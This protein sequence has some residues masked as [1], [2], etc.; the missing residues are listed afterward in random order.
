MICV[1]TTVFLFEEHKYHRG[2]SQANRMCGGKQ[3]YVL[4]KTIPC[5]KKFE[6]VRC[7]DSAASSFVVKF[8]AEV[9]TYFHAVFLES[10]SIVQN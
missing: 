1:K 6:S 8:R 4:G 9:F 2:Q 10:Y 7:L 5:L 3:V